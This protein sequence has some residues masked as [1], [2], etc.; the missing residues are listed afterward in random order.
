M[1]SFEWD[2]TEGEMSIRFQLDGKVFIL[3]EDDVCEA[4]SVPLEDD[5][6]FKVKWE[7]YSL[8]M[9]SRHNCVGL[10]KIP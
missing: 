8:K 2:E 10:H 1:S 4:L 5:I 7:H 9:N 3:K 6:Y